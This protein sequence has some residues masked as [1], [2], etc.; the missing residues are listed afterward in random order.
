MIQTTPIGY[1]RFMKAITEP[2]QAVHLF[3]ETGELSGYGYA[4][5]TID[6]ELWDEGVYPDILWEFEKS[7]TPSRVLGYYVTGTDGRIM[8]SENF[9]A[10][11]DNDDDLP[12]Y[13]IGRAG[14]RIAVGLRLNLFFSQKQEMHRVIEKMTQEDG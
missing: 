3:V 13:V 11:S 12:G 10:H 4:A 7:E 2:L 8:Y 5:E 6:P 9:P 1:S 14:D